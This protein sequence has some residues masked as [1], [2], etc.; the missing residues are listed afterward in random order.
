VKMAAKLKS[1]AIRA[2]RARKV[3]KRCRGNTCNPK[4]STRR[5]RLCLSRKLSSWRNPLKML[6]KGKE[7]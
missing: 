5:T 1:C 2:A 6:K 7:S 4:A 3:L